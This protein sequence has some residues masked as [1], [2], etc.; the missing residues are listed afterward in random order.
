MPKGQSKEA[1]GKERRCP[2]KEE[3]VP[4]NAHDKAYDTTVKSQPA[5][6]VDALQSKK[7]L[8]PSFQQTKTKIYLS[9][10]EEERACIRQPNHI[11]KNQNREAHRSTD[12]PTSSDESSDASSESSSDASSDVSSQASNEATSSSSSDA[13]R[14]DE[15]EHP[16]MCDSSSDDDLN[17]YRNIESR[18]EYE[19]DKDVNSDQTVVTRMQVDRRNDDGGIS[20][21]AHR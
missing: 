8:K 15:D 12:P 3:Q 7:L 18:G 11:E 1:Q 9:F 13:S 14:D 5:V 6:E 16:P 17:R 2:S 4:Q 10:D 20:T 21:R 19:Y